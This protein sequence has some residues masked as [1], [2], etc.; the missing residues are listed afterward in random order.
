LLE[1]I[2]EYQLIKIEQ[3]RANPTSIEQD[4]LKRLFRYRT[5]ADYEVDGKVLRLFM[6]GIDRFGRLMLVDEVNNSYCFNIKE[7]KFLF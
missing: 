1:R 6:T 5:W 2:V 7:I 3:L 4:Y